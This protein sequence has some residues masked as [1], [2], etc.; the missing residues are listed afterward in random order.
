MMPQIRRHLA[1]SPT[2]FSDAYFLIRVV[3]EYISGAVTEKK[4]IDLETLVGS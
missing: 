2:P 3:Y 1:I 4:E